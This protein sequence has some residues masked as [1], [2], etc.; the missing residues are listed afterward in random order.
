MP[1]HETVWPVRV[2]VGGYTILAATEPPALL[3]DFLARAHAV[4]EFPATDDRS[5][6][7]YFFV[8]VAHGSDWPQLD[9][10]QWFSPAGYGFAPGVLVVPDTDAVFIGAGTRLLGYQLDPGGWQRAFVDEADLG[11]WA[12]QQHGDVVVMSAELELAAWTTSCAKLWSMFVEPPWSYQVR[13]EEIQLDVMGKLTRFSL[14]A[15]P[16]GS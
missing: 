16:T 12:W 13:G 6:V 9:V 7:G 5:S 1:D 10:T 2:T 8:A 14:V 4:D 3:A 11:F 15:G